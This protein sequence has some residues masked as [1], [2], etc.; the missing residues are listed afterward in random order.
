M[1]RKIFFSKRA[2]PKFDKKI[3]DF[4]TNT[5]N[6]DFT[7]SKEVVEAWLIE[8]VDLIKEATSATMG[9]ASVDDGPNYIFPSYAIFD[10]VSK[11]RAEAIGY[12]V[13]SQIMSDELTDIDP[14]PIYPEGPVKA[15]T[16][17]PSRCCW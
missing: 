14:H 2:Y 5:L 15:V 12:T 1:I 7:I 10:R 8:N 16:P 17:Y 11:R 6:E 13:L 4:I 9:K 3:F